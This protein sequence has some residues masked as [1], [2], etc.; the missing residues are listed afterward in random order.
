MNKFVTLLNIVLIVSVSLGLAS[1]S[2]QMIKSHENDYVYSSNPPF[3]P[4]SKI[5]PGSLLSQQVGH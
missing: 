2:Q 4:V 3:V 1:C 5:P